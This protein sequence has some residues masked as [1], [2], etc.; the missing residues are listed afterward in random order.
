MDSDDLPSLRNKRPRDEKDYEESEMRV[1]VMDEEEYEE[2]DYEEEC[3]SLQQGGE[4]GDE[5]DVLSSGSESTAGTA[6]EPPAITP[7]SWSDT[8]PTEQLTIE[9]RVPRRT[10]CWLQ[11]WTLKDVK[12]MRP[13][14]KKWTKEDQQQLLASVK[15]V[16]AQP[17][18]V[19]GEYVCVTEQY[20]AAK[21][22][23]PGRLT[24]AGLQGLQG[25]IRANLLAETADIDMST[26]MHRILLWVC[27]QFRIATP[28]LEYYIRHRDG[29]NG[30][31]QYVMDKAA[32]TK[33]KAKELYTMAYTSTK[34]V[35]VQN[36]P[37]FKML[38]KEAKE[39]QQQLM[40]VQQLQWI[41]PLCKEENRPGSFIAHLFQW[42]ECKL[43][44]HVSNVVSAEF[45]TPVAA[46][47]FD[48]FNLADASLHGNTA[49]LDRAHAVCEQV[50]PG[51]DMRW[52]WKELD[53]MVKSK[54]TKKP[55]KEL[56]VPAGFVAPAVGSPEAATLDEEA[57]LGPNEFTYEQVR[58]SFSLGLEGPY[59]KV[60]ST[61]IKV[62]DD[63]QL[64]LAGDAKRFKEQHK[65]VKYWES[66]R[67]RN[68]ETGV[69]TTK[70]IK[71]PFIDAW[72]SDE[73]MDPK[74]LS[75]EDKDKLYYWDRFDMFPDKTKCPADVYN[76]W[77]GFSAEK[78]TTDLSDE[79]VRGGLVR[80]LKHFEMICSGEAKSY[81]FLLDLIA[82]AV[83]HPDKKLGVVICLVGAQGCGKGTVWDIIERLVG[84]SG[85]FTTKK[86]ERDVFG[87]FNGRMKDAFFV[88][89]AECTK[90]KL[91]ADE[92]KDI[93]TGHKID[94]HEKYCPVVEV[95]SYARFFIDT[96]R[97]DA[98]PDEHGERRYF[99]IK[100][101]EAMIG[102]DPDYFIP[103]RE[104]VL[105]DDRVIR[106]FFE[107][108]R[109]RTIKP[110]YHG[111]D[112]PV[113]E[114]A[115]AL[116][117]SK[118]SETEAFLEW[119]VEQEEM[120]VKTLHL[121]S[122]AFSTRYKTFKGEGEERSTD[123]IMKQLKLQSISGVDQHRARPQN[124]EW[125]LTCL[126][127]PAAPVQCSFC[128]GGIPD[129][130]D[131]VMRQYVV[132]CDVLRERYKIEEMAVPSAAPV[133]SAASI[134]CE[135]EVKSFCT[136]PPA[137]EDAAQATKAT[138]LSD[139]RSLS[140]GER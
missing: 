30:M 63:G 49:V 25:Q 29:P 115:R 100:C 3:D 53:F 72:M 36:C 31:L 80:I 136:Y 90:K 33:A 17:T 39:I 55:L 51:I 124:L 56:R 77:A 21:N 59:G 112:I 92:L 48:G 6:N 138:V 94:V 45:N 114:Y 103:L 89:M 38:D 69:A 40:Q 5:E 20:R 97:V 135:A 110:S 67:E 47:V 4:M 28:H 23:F 134:D 139:V 44:V 123:G 8:T 41:L 75:E 54:D 37:R 78:M 58:E 95:K 91:E 85:C 119:L 52:A 82:H 32:V 76:L 1:E 70:K 108:L 122:E 10:W 93:I 27:K 130:E 86:P 65:H 73:R 71:K 88:R 105:A 111:N 120:A 113:G 15:R 106:A 18:R 11:T 50:C 84:G 74:Y 12:A 57:T 125:C 131:K 14:D 43:V 121:T 140:N 99:I 128:A 104:E 101:N 64:T 9:A 66:V 68:V 107:F 129:S 116:K 79:A 24:S 132:D 42:I 34:P 96:N 109:A 126:G 87:H 16:L 137:P 83:Q 127:Y 102:H 26:C 2:Y 118:R 133:Q 98:I 7:F 19:D 61:Y 117:D 62:E 13:C 22:G 81:N 46:L 35:S 60:G